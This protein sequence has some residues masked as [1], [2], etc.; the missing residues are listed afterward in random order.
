MRRLVCGLGL[1]CRGRTWFIFL[2]SRTLWRCFDHPPTSK[3]ELYF[4]S[5]SR[6]PWPVLGWEFW[7][8]LSNS[9]P[10]VV[11]NL[12]TYRCSVSAFKLSAITHCYC[13]ERTRL[14]GTP[15][16]LVELDSVA[17]QWVW[18]QILPGAKFKRR[19]N[20]FLLT[21]VFT[22]SCKMTCCCP[23]KNKLLGRSY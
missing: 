19:G 18:Q 22:F 2:F 13:V 20:S 10:S 12:I 3:V 17:I 5:P 11:R 15:I 8:S 14:S 7:P 16:I 23:I 21:F 1:S 6:T 4:C 9:F